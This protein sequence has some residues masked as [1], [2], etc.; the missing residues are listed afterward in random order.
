MN[1]SQSSRP[2]ALLSETPLVQN[3]D[4]ESIISRVLSAYLENAGIAGARGNQAER[5]TWLHAAA[6]LEPARVETVLELIDSLLKQ[7]RV[8]EAILLA[9]NSSIP[10]R[11]MHLRS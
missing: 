2:E 5:S 6:L 9:R 11:S 10:I 8:A 4:Q 1:R 7:N 3:V